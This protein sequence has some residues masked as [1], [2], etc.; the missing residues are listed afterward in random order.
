LSQIATFEGDQWE[1]I[2][3]RTHYIEWEMVGVFGNALSEKAGAL[4][5]YRPRSHGALGEFNRYEAASLSNGF[6]AKP[7]RRAP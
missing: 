7:F 6:N 2:R 1:R 3:A 5:K 4:L